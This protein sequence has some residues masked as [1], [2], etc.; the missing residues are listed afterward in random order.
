MSASSAAKVID[1]T[2]TSGF[3][4]KVLASTDAIG[5]TVYDTKYATEIITVD[6]CAS[7]DDDCLVVL[8]LVGGGPFLCRLQRTGKDAKGRF[9][10]HGDGREAYRTTYGIKF[11]KEDIGRHLYVLGRVV[12]FPREFPREG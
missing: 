8:V 10:P 7:M 2:E 11:T 6:P 3:T 1:P 4:F 9:V 5:G 12:G